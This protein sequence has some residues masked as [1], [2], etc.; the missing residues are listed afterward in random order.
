LWITP[1]L[2]VHNKLPPAKAAHM[3]VQ[4]GWNYRQVLVDR[5]DRLDEILDGT[6]LTDPLT[7]M[8]TKIDEDNVK[9]NMLYSKDGVHYESIVYENIAQGILNFIQKPIPIASGDPRK[10]QSLAGISNNVLLGTFVLMALISMLLTFDIYL[11]FSSIARMVLQL[12]TIDVE[13]VYDELH[14]TID[15]IA[16]LW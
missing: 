16:K 11:G 10:I 15:K 8:T 9:D 5:S 7:E 6:T 3:T 12:P 13:A 14:K 4:A 2:V 1:T